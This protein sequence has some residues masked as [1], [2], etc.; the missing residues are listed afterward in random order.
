MRSE[1]RSFKTNQPE[2]YESSIRVDN[3]FFSQLQT[4]PATLSLNEFKQLIHPADILMF[5]AYI[6]RLYAT[7]EAFDCQLRYLK[8]GKIFV[9]LNLKVDF[10]YN[11]SQ[12][13]TLIISSVKPEVKDLTKLEIATNASG[14]EFWETNLI[15]GKIT[16]KAIKIFKDL[17]YT[18]EESLANIDDFSSFIHPDD[19]PNLLTAIDNHYRKITDELDYRQNSRHKSSS[20]VE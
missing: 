9:L 14:H 11:E 6:E 16:R 5:E 12:C 13:L 4:P 20:K 10:C 8:V 15:T 3:Y 19:L 2:L 18:E 1:Q 17:G 7:G